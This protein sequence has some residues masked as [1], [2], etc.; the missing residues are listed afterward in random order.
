MPQ[1]KPVQVTVAF[2]MV[3]VPVVGVEWWFGDGER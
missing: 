1:R 2:V 3:S